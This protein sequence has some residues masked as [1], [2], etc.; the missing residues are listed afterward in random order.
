MS[1][2]ELPRVSVLLVDDRAENLT[3]L[4]AILE[5][6]GQ[7]L[8]RASSGDAA[9]RAVLDEHFA[10]ILMDV[11]MPGL[12]GIET[13]ELL[14]LRERSRHIPIIFL[15]AFDE[16]IVRGYSAG[17]VDFM[18]KPYHPDALRAKVGV[19]V[20]LRQNELAL[21]AVRN[22]LEAR[23]AARTA[24]LAAA[25]E[26]L[27]REIAERT[28]AERKLFEQAHHDPLTGLANRAL[29]MEH[30]GAAVAR[31]RRRASPSFAVM[32]LDLDR[33]KYV[34]DTH[35]H[36]AGDQL[37]VAVADRL[38]RCLRE[39]DLAARLGGDEFAVLLDGVADVSDATRS[40]ERIAD[41]ISMPV[42][43]EGRPLHAT[44]SIGIA[45]R[46][47]D[48]TRAEDLL[49]DA[50]AAM[51]RAKELGRARYHVFDDAL[52]SLVAARRAAR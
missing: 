25:N 51:Y 3:A 15:S 42:I 35:G 20:H 50:D 2:D 26:A 19:F 43:I 31:S 7:R 24:E 44:A 17:A 9:L 52:R 49:R 4:E 14:K 40:A 33:F 1:I 47:A 27:Q 36:L 29:L 30:L 37:L 21:E 22:E 8:V 18:L 11:A 32:L 16:H 5:P 41:A 10:V 46:S 38:R 13:F 12:D 45:M 23:V 39:A 48:H 34:N 6:L 28:A